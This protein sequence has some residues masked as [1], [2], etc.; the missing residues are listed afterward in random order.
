MKRE[1]R[2]SERQMDVPQCIVGAYS[3]EVFTDK[4]RVLEEYQQRQ[5]AENRE[6]NIPFSPL[7]S[8]QLDSV[9]QDK[10]HDDREQNNRCVPTLS[11]KIEKD[12]EYRSNEIL[13]RKHAVSK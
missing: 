3:E 11:H 4:A 12:A 13:G 1:K 9:T 7:A 6:P 2:N 8:L 10:I 5:I